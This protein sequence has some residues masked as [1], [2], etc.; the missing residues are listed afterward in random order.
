MSDNTYFH[1]LGPGSQP[2][3]P[4]FA[5]NP[6]PITVGV[7]SE[8]P[9]ATL[10][11]YHNVTEALQLIEY[12]LGK[13]TDYQGD[14]VHYPVAD[15]SALDD[16]NR[17]FLDVLL[18]EGEVSI[19]VQVDETTE[20]QIQES[21]FCG[22]WR[23]WEIQHGQRVADRIEICPIPACVCYHAQLYA[24]ESALLPPVGQRQLMNALPLAHE[25]LS[26]A[27]KAPQP[28]HVINLTSLPLTDD[29]RSFLAD[30]AGQGNERIRTRGYGESLIVS[31]GLK[32]VWNIR[33][34]NG[35]KGILLETYEVSCIPEVALASV[36]DIEDSAQRLRDT[37]LWFKELTHV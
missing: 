5:M 12:L 18:G 22:F 35:L 30:T 8:P 25:L 2:D 16:N 9:M 4:D 28:A 37:Y 19:V 29:D 23:V 20:I 15:V 6:L 13:C 32:N 33:C 10:E 34:L 27:G 31:T 26:Q 11:Q 1:L 36:E 17:H 7:A 3:D 24:H 21:I 14:P